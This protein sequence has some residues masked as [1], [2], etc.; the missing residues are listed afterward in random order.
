MMRVEER[1]VLLAQ[2]SREEGLAVSAQRTLQQQKQQQQQ[3]QQNGEQNGERNTP[4]PCSS[5]DA[6]RSPLS[7]GAGQGLA[8]RDG[9]SRG[10]YDPMG[11][12]S[13]P[14]LTI[15]YKQLI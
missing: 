12:L 1:R 8:H 4:M 14:D 7:V 6:L 11:I 10:A 15:V 3:Q 9:E 5:G 13:S 2:L